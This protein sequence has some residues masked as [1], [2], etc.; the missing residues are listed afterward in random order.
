M[1]LTITTLVLAILPASWALALTST[2][3]SF[4]NG[5]NSYTG[6]YDRYIAQ[7]PDSGVDGSL[8]TDVIL[9]GNT[10]QG[11]IRFDNIFGTNPGQIPLGDRILDASL[12]LSTIGGPDQSPGPNTSNGPYTV[13][14]LTSPFNNT[15]IYSSYPGLGANPAVG[16]WF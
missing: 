12:Q 6:T 9:I 14:G 2:T 7:T 8:L 10:Q 4:Q 5:V 13:S 11:L 3:V 15:T 1:R 16:A